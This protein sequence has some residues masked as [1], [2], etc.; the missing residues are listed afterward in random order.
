MAEAGGV[1]P[2]MTS[3]TN[4]VPCAWI[5]L[6]EIVEAASRPF[7]FN[8][9]KALQQILQSKSSEMQLGT[10]VEMFLVIADL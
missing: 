3:I 7:G 10:L 1:G 2:T 4:C 6:A 5:Y 8:N 9:N